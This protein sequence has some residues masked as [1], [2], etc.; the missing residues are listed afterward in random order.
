[1][2]KDILI[3]VAVVVSLGIICGI[4]LALASHFM[5]IKKDEKAEKLRAVLPG[6]NCGACG[7]TGC[8]GYAAALAKGEAKPNLCVPGADKVAAEISNIL[9]ISFEDVEEM[10]AFVHCNGNNSDSRK[11]SEYE[12][13]KSCKA[14]ALVYGGPG[15][16]IQ[17]SWIR[18]LRRC[19][20]EQRDMRKRRRRKSRSPALHRLRTL[21]KNMSEKNNFAYSRNGKD[22]RYMFQQRKRRICPQRMPKRLYRLQKMRDELSRRR[23]KSHRQSRRDRLQKMHALRHMRRCLPRKMHKENGLFRK[24]PYRIIQKYNFQKP[25]QTLHLQINNKTRG[26]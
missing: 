25:A 12:G 17:L 23:Y 21:C 22:R 20:P 2:I 15:V 24:S 6:V 11:K 13:I 8:D 5:A 26:R 9:G 10:T 1:M 14:A 3:A 19:L 4:V 16:R 7:Y 18:R